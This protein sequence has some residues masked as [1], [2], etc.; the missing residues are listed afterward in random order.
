VKALTS[1]F[2][3]LAAAYQR[4]QQ[5]QELLMKQK[6]ER[7]LTIHGADTPPPEMLAPPP[8]RLH[9]DIWLVWLG[10]L[11]W[12]SLGINTFEK[13]VITAFRRV[14]ARELETRQWIQKLITKPPA[15]D[16]DAIN[17]KLAMEVG[18][19]EAEV[20]RQSRRIMLLAAVPFAFIT[21][22]TPLLGIWLLLRSQHLLRSGIVAHAE[23]ISRRRWTRSARLSF[24]AI[25]MRRFVVVKTLPDYVPIGVKLWILYSPRNPKHV[26]VYGLAGEFATLAAK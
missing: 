4:G 16:R 6:H 26:Y 1:I 10:L 7:F 12:L 23:V 13:D 22:I 8:R 2:G 14:E 20:A 25:D 21:V 11:L 17:Q 5:Q 9:R 18:E 3:R 19:T 24:T 15:G